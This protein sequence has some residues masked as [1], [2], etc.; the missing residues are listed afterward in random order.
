ME[1]KRDWGYAP[2]YV[3]AMWLMLQQEKPEDYV[4]ATNEAHSVKELA[5]KAFSIVGLNWEEHVKVD[6]RFLR[7]LEVDILCGD[8]SK[9]KR[10]FG[11]EP[12]TRFNEM[13]EIMVR[14][15]KKRWERWLNGERFPWDAPSYP[16]ENELITRALGK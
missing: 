3:E 10:H 4:I 12:K 2:E 15:D 7:P 13:V 11:W 5:Q 8:Y 1:A 14:E 16:H 6:K 9:A